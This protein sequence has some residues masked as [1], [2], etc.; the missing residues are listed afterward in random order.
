MM[1]NVLINNNLLKYQPIFKN[2]ILFAFVTATSI[3]ALLNFIG[4]KYFVFFI[5]HEN[6]KTLEKN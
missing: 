4:M 5:K 6:K 3:S 2:Q 1:I